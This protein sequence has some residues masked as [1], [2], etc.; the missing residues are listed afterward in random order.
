MPSLVSGFDYGQSF[1]NECRIEYSEQRPEPRATNG[2]NPL[3]AYFDAHKEGPGIW[4]W[5]HYFDIYHRHFAKFIGQEVHILEI[6]VYSGGSLGMWRSY[7]GDRCHVYGIDIEEACKAYEDLGVQIFIGDQADRLFWKRFKRD[8]PNIDIV[9][10]DGGHLPDQQMITLEELLP[11]I[12][13]NGVY[14]CE[15]VH[16]TMHR[17]ST[18][19]NGVTH[20]LNAFNVSDEGIA[21]NPFQ[22]AVQSVHH[23]P[24]V[25][26]IEKLPVPRHEFQLERH[27]TQ[28]EPFL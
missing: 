25:V 1:E 10:D 23:Y 18:F 28:W 20:S 8:V 22:A 17:F 7:F 12:R 16:G 15:D 24:F 27:G 2:E 5:R 14:M 21:A 3:T 13:T 9:I 26:V 6:G 11:H 19:V 4:K